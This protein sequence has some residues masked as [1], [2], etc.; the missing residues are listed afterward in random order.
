MGESIIIVE[1]AREEV[2]KGIEPI[3]AIKNAMVQFKIAVEQSLNYEFKGLKTSKRKQKK[4]M[5]NE[6]VENNMGLVHMIAKKKYN[7]YRNTSYYEDIIQEGTIGL[8]KAWNTFDKSKGYEFSTYA[9]KCIYNEMR[10]YTERFI[11]SRKHHNNFEKV[12]P[13]SFENYLYSTG[14][15][16]FSL[17]DVI[18]DNCNYEHLEDK[19]IIEDFIEYSKVNG[20]EQMQEIV[21]LAFDGLSQVD[22]AKKLDLGKRY[23][24]YNY[25]KLVKSFTTNYINEMT[26][27]KRC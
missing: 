3:Q 11:E 12:I 26:R 19:F 22:I 4:M 27:I 10:K 5:V 20:I 16:N 21:R 2:L 13:H 25:D 14:D 8:I 24:Q 7:I 17:K 18:P 15:E 23:V 9:C 1:L 6:V